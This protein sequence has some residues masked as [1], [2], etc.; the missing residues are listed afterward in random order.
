VLVCCTAALALA[1]P[2][3]RTTGFAASLPR[4]RFPVGAMQNTAS[5]VHV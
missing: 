1:D 2:S 4:G 5:Q 3:A